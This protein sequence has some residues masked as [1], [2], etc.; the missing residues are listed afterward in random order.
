MKRCY[1]A[2]LFSLILLARGQAHDR[3]L[4]LKSGDRVVLLGSTFLERA[5]RYGFLESELTR[6]HPDKQIV[7]RN[8]AWSGDTVFG[9]SWIYA[10][11]H[12]DH[13]LRGDQLYSIVEQQQPTVIIV[14]YGA[15]EAFEGQP[16]LARWRSGLGRMLDRLSTIGARLV[17]LT[18]PPQ[19]PSKSRA[20][21]K[22]NQNLSMYME[23]MK[24]IASKR[25]LSLID[26]GTQLQE[27]YAERPGTSLTENGLHLTEA[28]YRTAARLL[29][30]SIHDDPPAWT[31]TLDAQ[32]LQLQTGSSTAG[33]VARDGERITFSGEDHVL[34]QPPLDEEASEVRRVLKVTGLGGGNYTLYIDGTEIL[35]SDAAG[36]ARGVNLDHGPAFERAAAL[37][38]AIVEKNRLFFARWRPE[39]ETYLRGFRRHEQGRNVVELPLFDPLIAKQEEL[40]ARL[41]KPE[42]NDYHLIPAA[43]RSEIGPETLPDSDPA[44][45]LATFQVAAGFEVSLFASE[46]MVTNPINMNWDA[47]GRLWVATSPIY[48]HLKPGQRAN[49]KIIVLEDTDGDGRADKRTVFADHLLV[50]TA[51]LPGDGGAYVANSSELVHLSDTDGDGRADQTRVL[52]SG[53]G[54]EDTHQ[55]LH[56]FRW[57]PGGQLFFNQS[58]LINSHV[59]TPHG[60]RRLAAGGV[61]EYDVRAGSLDVYARGMVNPWGFQFDRWGQSFATDG[62]YREGINFV[63]P[64]AAF[65]WAR[66]VP[67][68]LKGL[69][70]GQPKECG[71]EILSGRHLPAP[72]QHRLLTADFR[73]HR[74]VSFALSE[75]QSGYFSQQMEDLIQSDHVAFR[76]VDIK[77]GPDGAIYIC[78]WYNSIIN[79]G[80]VDFR[81]PRRDHH[82]GRIWRVTANDRPLVENPRLHDAEVPAL[83]EALKAPEQWTRDMARQVLKDRDPQQ[84]RAGL[85]EWIETLDPAHPDFHQQ[86]LEAIWAAQTTGT[87][88]ADYL[89]ELLRSSDHRVR[90]AAVRVLSHHR[91]GLPHALSWLAEAVVDDHPRVRLEAINALRAV[92]SL[93]AFEVA[94]R[95]LDYPVDELIDFALWVT[96]RDL[97]PV[98]LPQFEAG[99]ISLGGDVERVA[100]VLAASGK[101]SLLLPLVDRYRSGELD[102]EARAKVAQLIAATGTAKELRLVFDRCL[103]TPSPGERATLLDHLMAAARTRRIKPSGGLEPLIELILDEPAAMSLA[104]LWQLEAARPLLEQ[105]AQDNSH[106]VAAR[107]RA[108]SALA[109]LGSRSLPAM[110]HVAQT[111]RNGSIQAAAIAAIASL[112]VHQAATSAVDALATLDLADA[113]V[114]YNGFLSQTSGPQAL[115]TKLQDRT[116]PLEV[117]ALGLNKAAALGERAQS[118]VEALTAAGGVTTSRANLSTQE[119]N[120]LL[121]DVVARGNP[122][123]GELVYRRA[124]LGCTKCHAIG[125]AGGKV[126]PDLM[127][128]GASAPLDYIA[129]SLV[130]PS[131]KIKE[132][133]E[134]TVVILDS[135]QVLSGTVIGEIGEHFLLRDAENVVQ[136]VP[137]QQ[138]EERATQPVSL[139]PPSLTDTLSH[140]DFVDLVSFLTALGKLPEFRV[141][142]RESVRIWQTLQ[143]KGL[144]DANEVPRLSA[145]QWVTALSLA[146]GD[147]SLDSLTTVEVGSTPAYVVRFGVNVH[148]AGTIGLRISAPGNVR[149]WTGQQPSEMDGDTLLADVEAGPQWV[150]LVVEASGPQN[151]LRVQRLESAEATARFA[152]KLE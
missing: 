73:A 122:A 40:I 105:V 111:D 121:E 14:G 98:W 136:R 34:P 35:T 92:G 108:I 119:W 100:F 24:E 28:G 1:L 37:R 71:L 114:V 112:D 148:Q 115:A 139:M 149:A 142:T 65:Y 36:F 128:L 22:Y 113:E 49:D 33:E 81:D 117:A 48:P 9:D 51:V 91:T 20:A 116:L 13:T 126:G 133:Y 99:R 70:P 55:I 8:L 138:V 76:P 93:A 66:G 60:V 12:S 84:V 125:G 27:F 83:L 67:R 59:E 39:N 23:V 50:P 146:G 32:T 41:R 79:H 118:L 120:G 104:G 134:T 144:A 132:G 80:E 90:A 54:T 107:Q 18:S 94:L 53:F 77:M 19:D 127:S 140:E 96:V 30:K 101:H 47:L 64:G 43:P 45:E 4:Q 7:F 26:L 130:F 135:G 123:R 109:A 151:E 21:A 75:S 31:V 44:Q 52:L 78:D 2:L 68:I 58:V 3:P 57:G 145:G 110:A 61:W 17:L 97:E 15:V 88:S 42:R 69:N 29:V 46:P 150:T 95:A 129:E 102:E 137:S 63:W 141:P 6:L 38:Q 10:K 103:E 56:A 82:H 147:L 74:V 25:N 124:A 89:Q 85:A 106:T 86:R 152:F 72:W 5:Q 131:R 143:G 87:V 16:G 62:A 11:S